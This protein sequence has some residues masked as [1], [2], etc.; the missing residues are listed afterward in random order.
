MLEK[1][2]FYGY[3][4]L[5]STYSLII[6][7]IFMGC[8]SFL[9][10]TGR[11]NEIYVNGKTT[12]PGYI[13]LVADNITGVNSPYSLNELPSNDETTLINMKNFKFII[14]H[15]RCNKT[16][17]LLLILIHS[18]P[19]NIAKR[20]VIRETW[21]K[22]T[23]EIIVLFFIGSTKKY[24]EKIIN[25]DNEFHDIIQGNFIDVY[26]NM[27]YKHVMVLK[28]ATYYCPSAKYV[29]KL[30]DDV[31]VHIPAMIDYLKHD[32]SAWGAR[33]LILCDLISA[34]EV[35]R[36]WRSKWRVSPLEYPDRHYPIYCAGWAILYSPDSVFLLYRGAQKQPY[37]WIDDVHITGT[38]A[39]KVNITRSTWHSLVLKN[40]EIDKLLNNP[41]DHREFLLGPPNLGREKIKALHRLSISNNNLKSYS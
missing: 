34:V 21:G 26:R 10:L 28:W 32:L 25:E 24:Q 27:T 41:N 5:P 31:F 39:E 12:P 40:D 20:N 15:E 9:M 2:R 38:V 33:R 37:F 4:S 6:A 16:Q 8:L 11:H 1:R 30:D 7:L 3:V 36:S 17:P 29:L 18:A 35:K 13:L 19:S 22:E 23:S 14:N